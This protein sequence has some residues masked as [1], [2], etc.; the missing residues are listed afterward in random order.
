MARTTERQQA[1]ATT[2]AQ[3]P[4]SVGPQQARD[5]AAGFSRAM[6][7]GT[8][9][10]AQA[11]TPR[12]PPQVLRADRVHRAV[13]GY[14]SALHADAER[15]GPVWT[16]T[17]A[18]REDVDDPN[19][20]IAPHLRQNA[21]QLF[22]QNPTEIS[23]EHAVYAHSDYATRRTVFAG[24]QGSPVIRPAAELLDPFRPER[25]RQ[26]IT[27]WVH[28]EPGLVEGGRLT[29]DP[30]EHVTGRTPL[31][32]SS[33][34]APIPGS[35]T[36]AS[37]FDLQLG[38]ESLRPYYGVRTRELPQ[39]TRLHVCV[40][41][42]YGKFDRR[43]GHEANYDLCRDCHSTHGRLP[44]DLY[45]SLRADLNR[46]SLVEG[47]A[48]TVTYDPRFD[49]IAETLRQQWRASHLVFG[50]SSGEPFTVNPQ[51][52]IATRRT[53]SAGP[54]GRPIS[55]PAAEVPPEERL[56]A[57]RGHYP[58]LSRIIVDLSHELGDGLRRSE[59]EMM[60]QGDRSWHNDESI[61]ESAEERDGVSG[62]AT[63]SDFTGQGPVTFEKGAGL[64]D[65]EIFALSDQVSGASEG[66]GRASQRPLAQD[67]PEPDG[68]GLYQ[69]L[70]RDAPER[71]ARVLVTHRLGNPDA[72][73]HD[74]PAAEILSAQALRGLPT[75]EA[76]DAARRALIDS[77]WNEALRENQQWE[78]RRERTREHQLKL[79]NRDPE[80]TA[81][82]REREVARIE[83]RFAPAH[84]KAGPLATVTAPTIVG[85]PSRGTNFTGVDESLGPHEANAFLR[86]HNDRVAKWL[87]EQGIDPQQFN[88]DYPL[89]PGRELGD[90]TPRDEN[91][92]RIP[93]HA[94][95]SE[96]EA[97][98]Q[99]E[100]QNWA[101]HGGALSPEAA[102]AAIAEYRAATSPGTG[103]PASL[104]ETDL[105]F[106][107]S[108]RVDVPMARAELATW[109]HLEKTT[110]ESALASLVAAGARSRQ[111][112]EQAIS[113]LVW[114]RE[115]GEV[116]WYYEIDSFDELQPRYTADERLALQRAEADLRAAVGL[117]DA[118]VD[119]A[120]LRTEMA[121]IPGLTDSVRSEIS[122][123]VRRAAAAGP[124]ALMW[125]V[126]E[127]Q[128]ELHQAG[129]GRP[130]LWALNSVGDYPAPLSVPPAAVRVDETRFS[131]EV[132]R[133]AGFT[134]TE[135]MQIVVD[136]RRAAMSGPAAFDERLFA[137]DVEMGKRG[138]S[139][140]D[141]RVLLS[142]VDYSSTPDP[143]GVATAAGS[144]LE[145]GGHPFAIDVDLARGALGN[146][147]FSDPEGALASL[148]GAA[149]RGRSELDRAVSD[150]V[151]P[152]R[153]VQ[154]SP[155]V[156][157]NRS[158][159]WDGHEGE[160]VWP[161]IPDS[162]DKPYDRDE[163]NDRQFTEADL[164]AVLGLPGARI[165]DSRL[166][167]EVAHI[168]GLLDR[169]RTA[170]VNEIR[171]AAKAGPGA[172]R[173][174][175]AELDR[176]LRIRG[177][178][179]PDAGALLSVADY[180]GEVVHRARPALVTGSEALGLRAAPE[181]VPIAADRL[182]EHVE[183]WSWLPE[184]TR[185]V[186]AAV[187][188]TATTRGP[189]PFADA[190]VR[191]AW[192]GDPSDSVG[193]RQEAELTL[194]AEVGLG[195]VRVDGD[196]LARVIDTLPNWGHLDDRERHALHR[197]IM[198]AARCGPGALNQAM[199]SAVGE[200][201]TA[202]W[203]GGDTWNRSARAALQATVGEPSV[204]R[205]D[206]GQTVAEIREVRFV[207]GTASV[208]PAFVA[209]PAARRAP[210]PDAERLWP[211]GRLIDAHQALS[212]QSATLLADKQELVSAAA[213]MD[214]LH[215]RVVSTGREFLGQLA[216]VLAD[217]AAFQQHFRALAPDEKRG[218][219]D[220]IEKNPRALEERIGL[221]GRLAT[222]RPITAQTAA[223]RTG[224][225]A[226]L[227]R[228][229]GAGD[230]YQ[231][232][233][234]AP[235]VARLG[236]AYLDSTQ[237]YRDRIAA[238]ATK[239]D[240]TESTRAAVRKALDTRIGQI[241]AALER[242]DA[243]RSG[244]GREPD[245]GQA[246]NRVSQLNRAEQRAIV[247]RFPHATAAMKK[248]AGARFAAVFDRRRSHRETLVEH[249]GQHRS[250]KQREKH[251]GGFEM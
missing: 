117:P 14:L 219:L 2:A 204:L 64:S 50:R 220:V 239:L 237:A 72:H 137:L 179:L 132:A 162:G 194:R 215:T 63:P 218:L 45:H 123:D 73:F 209:D 41:C 60:L 11:P 104:S 248:I 188:T 66:Q 180:S 161:E 175:V 146:L 62:A 101:Q 67:V 243:Q 55:R 211:E 246:Y 105:P 125:R 227:Q 23:F 203:S 92:R 157:E 245:H 43:P 160:W 147:E 80:L 39:P 52:D 115:P 18:R 143:V 84:L 216:G 238:A 225:S 13:L 169:E 76:R 28:A 97:A 99:A 214:R 133:L 189:G 166:V 95:I 200:S 196:R 156:L 91:D 87:V 226:V 119:E 207:E 24:F 65:D 57:I 201:V 155:A 42:S 152:E 113:N 5:S 48:R 68:R 29:L 163:R 230:H 233:T 58:T 212:R 190:V 198:N 182:R 7:R 102:A 244:L 224:L 145:A 205:R 112:L 128:E 144:A 184:S 25:L 49:A 168:P 27:G 53:L 206:L 75:P 8:A 167:A 32:L 47:A 235:A 38:R 148:V 251:R 4:E 116:K 77:D 187:M 241:G 93:L 183:T 186:A 192:R 150:L 10:P 171:T 51:S 138:H 98:L 151:W 108:V 89:N 15:F 9:L 30:R 109:P 232:L 16:A 177:N 172:L 234:S 111:N 195:G 142:V 59:D 118:R 181:S 86:S 178:P 106:P 240:R 185:A 139:I 173:E 222:S 19:P 1:E 236:H 191:F 33:P 199:D 154:V 208:T 31:P 110:A 121:K 100:A 103:V 174:Q 122:D 217:P 83:E 141:P 17:R 71:E 44:V 6:A 78:A 158:P 228:A 36:W 81:K 134:D 131:A 96:R 56:H 88:R 126:L 197:D 210:A 242:I 223:G 21:G 213:E 22:P 250:I 193:V 34:A 164:R 129:Q 35:E 94:R 221:A 85:R 82:A 26:P 12:V 130:D 127:L 176:G 20:A 3:Q 229:Q 170:T 135:H 61:W 70:L 165:D 40:A 79:V 159:G 140:Q 249:S 74:G 120:L 54:D 107:D 202:R 90:I 153:D 114:S 69:W 231:A 46:R 37:A 247:E 124:G 136:L 149:S